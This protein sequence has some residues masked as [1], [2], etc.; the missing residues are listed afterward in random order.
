MIFCSCQKN[1]QLRLCR[2]FVFAPELHL[3]LAGG[4][5]SSNDLWPIIHTIR[6]RA[7]P[8]L[9]RRRKKKPARCNLKKKPSGSICL[10]SL[11]P[12]RLSNCRPSRLEDPPGLPVRLRYWHPHQR[13]HRR[14]LQPSRPRVRA[15]FKRHLSSNV[16][17]PCSARLR[18]NRR[19]L[20]PLTR[21]WFIRLQLPQSSAWDSTFMFFSVF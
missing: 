5:L 2:F 17:R 4:R 7:L 8:V 13:L 9:S 3:T 12:P 16:L 15:K 14:K 10:P 1:G 11:P 21:F 19:P 18:P 20:R 6:R